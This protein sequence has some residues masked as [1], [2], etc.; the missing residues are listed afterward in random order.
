MYT[1]D[2]QPGSSLRAVNA[3]N[4]LSFL[5]NPDTLVEVLSVSFFLNSGL[6]SID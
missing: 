3:L 4:L 1:A 2:S 5:F 6:T